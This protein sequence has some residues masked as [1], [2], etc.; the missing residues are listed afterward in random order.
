MNKGGKIVKKLYVL[1]MVLLVAAVVALPGAAQ[2]AMWVG[3]E[4]GGNLVGSSN[5]DLKASAPG[6]NASATASGV[7]FD[8]PQVIGGL[9]VGYD[10]VNSGFGAYAWPD[11]MKYFSFATDFTYNRFS[12]QSQTLVSAT[13][14]S[15]G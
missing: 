5:A 8:N 11:W 15:M 9:T 1:A 4:L 13:S 14:I 3:G 7:A 2:S 12:I 6:L 10:F